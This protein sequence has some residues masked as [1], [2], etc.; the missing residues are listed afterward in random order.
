MADYLLIGS[1]DPFES[2]D[3]TRLYALAENL[4]KNGSKVTL[5]LVQNGVLSARENAQSTALS[6]VAGNGVEVLADEFSLRE[7]GI[8][9]DG[10]VSGV[11]A[12]PLEVVVDQLTE[13]RKAIWN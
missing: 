12:A 6:S 11:S 8:A 9:P 4:V 7:R 1:R 13:G 5:F 10:L 2:N 3:V